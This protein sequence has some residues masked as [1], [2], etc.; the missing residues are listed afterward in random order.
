MRRGEEDEGGRER[1]MERLGVC[2]AR[3][4]V[5]DVMCGTCMLVG[6]VNPCVCRLWRMPGLVNP[7]ETKVCR[8]S[9]REA[10]VAMLVSANRLLRRKRRSPPYCI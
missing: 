1:A 7:R 3:C 4:V 6:V 2:C 10:S 8:W 5:C 9:S